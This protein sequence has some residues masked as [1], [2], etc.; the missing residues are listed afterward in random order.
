MHL[1]SIQ[2]MFFHNNAQNLILNRNCIKMIHADMPDLFLFRK[3]VLHGIVP[4]AQWQLRV[5]KQAWLSGMLTYLL[6]PRDLK[7]I[8]LGQASI[9]LPPTALL[10]KRLSGG[11]W[12]FTFTRSRGEGESF[13][14]RLDLKSA[15]MF[16]LQKSGRRTSVPRDRP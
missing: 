16:N 7:E 12:L 14:S 8:S 1:R 15:A 10:Y 9:P 3:S 5:P 13:S 6:A 2:P 11:T 4:K